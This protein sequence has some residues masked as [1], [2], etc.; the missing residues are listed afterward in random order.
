MTCV[1]RPARLWKQLNG[2]SENEK[3]GKVPREEVVS[4]KP[5]DFGSSCGSSE[6]R[7]AGEVLREEVVSSKF[8]ALPTRSC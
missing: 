3:A 2:I 8:P 5:S 4:S 6:S 7:K 1:T